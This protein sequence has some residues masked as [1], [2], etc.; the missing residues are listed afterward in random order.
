MGQVRPGGG[1]LWTGPL[2]VFTA[3]TDVI[4][5]LR[6]RGLPG[7]RRLR[8]DGGRHVR[9]P[10]ALSGRCTARIGVA[11]RSREGSTRGVPAAVARGHHLS[12]G[13]EGTY[14]ASS[15]QLLCS[16]WVVPGPARCAGLCEP[17]RLHVCLS[18]AFGICSPSG[19][20]AC[21]GG[22]VLPAEGS[23]YAFPIL[24]GLLYG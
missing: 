2:S 8:A 24:F 18:S 23:S 9:R 14:G 22:I 4:L 21:T 5:E 7:S 17:A 19:H 13:P 3:N 10:S 11:H 1:G 6:S 12:E 15:L 20:G 16:H